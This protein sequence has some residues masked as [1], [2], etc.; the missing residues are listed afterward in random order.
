MPGTPIKRALDGDA[1]ASCSSTFR[2]RLTPDQPA[3]ARKSPSKKL[4]ED[5]LIDLA[6]ERLATC[7]RPS[8]SAR[9]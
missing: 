4:I 6:L 5:R 8:G 7:L 3:G 2:L 1:S 9:P